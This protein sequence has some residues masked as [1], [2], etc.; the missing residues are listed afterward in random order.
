MAAVSPAASRTSA[1]AVSAPGIAAATASSGS[2]LMSIKPRRM[3]RAGELAGEFGADAGRAAG[4][5][6]HAPVEVPGHRRGTLNGRVRFSRNMSL[7]GD[8]NPNPQWQRPEG[9]WEQPQWQSGSPLGNDADAP[10]A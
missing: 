9:G 8:E 3:P 2:R 5:E 7:P 4:D 1:T 6:R 10:A